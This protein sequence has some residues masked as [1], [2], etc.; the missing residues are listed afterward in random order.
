MILVLVGGNPNDPGGLHLILGLLETVLEAILHQGL[1]DQLGNEDAVQGFIK[2]P[3]VLQILL[4]A[5]FHEIEI[6]SGV[7]D[8]LL[9]GDRLAGIRETVAKLAGQFIAHAKYRRILCNE[10]C[11]S[12]DRQGVI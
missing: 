4:I 11:H 7:G 5:L 9:Q 3:L 12:Y 10:P 8:L 1:Q 2:L 6:A